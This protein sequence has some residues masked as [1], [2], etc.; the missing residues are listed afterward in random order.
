MEHIEF[1]SL[2]PETAPA[3]ARPVLQATQAKFGFVPDP[4]AKAAHAP[5]L[6]KHLLAG[7][8][9]F[10]Q[11]S[12]TPEEREVVAFAVAWEVECHYCMALHSAQ[13][14]SDNPT[15]TEALRTGVALEDPK[16]EALRQFASA[17][18]VQRGRPAEGQW[19]AMSRAG[20]GQ[21]QILEVT[22]GVGA[23]LLS[24]LTNVLTGVKLDAP[25]E[26]WR[27]QKPG[28]KQGILSPE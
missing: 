16:L 21:N 27:W 4:V 22:L 6:L 23:Y 17:I 5:A 1:E 13:L 18:V 9:L 7:L 26:R 28:A 2:T 11:T 8:T 19:A 14:A 25:F 3:A 12:L 20:F 10:E 24:T 15:L